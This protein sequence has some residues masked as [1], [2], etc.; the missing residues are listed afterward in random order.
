MDPANGQADRV[1]KSAEAQRPIKIRLSPL[2]RTRSIFGVGIKHATK[3]VQSMT[4][5]IN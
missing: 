5:L 2:A 3:P 1:E 4:D